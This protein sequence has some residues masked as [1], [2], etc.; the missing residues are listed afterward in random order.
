LG[1][2]ITGLGFVITIALILLLGFI[3]SNVIGKRLIHYGES[4]IPWMPIVHQLYSG[5]KQFMESFSASGDT[6]RMQPVLTEFP[7][8]GMRVI[9]F[10][11]SEL[12]DE[13]G[14][15][16]LTVFVPT[17]PNPTSGF[18]QIVEEHEVIRTD[19]SLEDALKMVVSAGKV[20]S[21]DVIQQLFSDSKPATDI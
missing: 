6:S 12:T 5:I 13:S 10:V 11:T 19:I 20:A 9:G 3:A 4:A 8:K 2:T 17:S 7:R 21:D 16:L 14:K 15:K 1:Q 18:L